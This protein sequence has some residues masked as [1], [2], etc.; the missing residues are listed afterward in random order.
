MEGEFLQALQA[1]QSGR[2][3][4][5]ELVEW[6]HHARQRSRER[7]V[8]S[9]K[10]VEALKEGEVKQADFGR[11]MC[12]RDG[13]VA[14]VDKDWSKILSVWHEPSNGIELCKQQITP[15][16]M[17][18]H[19]CAVRRA[20]DNS[21]WTSHTVAVVDQSGSMRKLDMDSY[22]MRF[23]VV[24]LTL[25]LSVVANGLRSKERTDTDMLS[26]VTMQNSSEI[27][28]AH[29]PFDWILY[30]KIVDL[31]R[32]SIPCQGGCYKPALETAAALFDMSRSRR[33]ALSLVFLSDGRP[34][35]QMQPGDIGTWEEKWFDTP[36]RLLQ[37]LLLPSENAF[38]FA[39]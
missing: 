7:G 5:K 4:R 39:W 17:K 2:L 18:D 25:A 20:R 14:I 36:R 33:C 9:R 16:M 1:G 8:D 15:D 19:I 23:D 22:T 24:W 35:D 32:S 11:W 34:S 37:I 29:E 13:C 38:Q 3:R 10:A 28:I 31:L 27:V 26:V 21:T 6:T 12:K 30:N